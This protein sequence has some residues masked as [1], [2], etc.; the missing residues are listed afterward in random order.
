ME[1]KMENMWA[2]KL[3][4]K[5]FNT[6]LFNQLQLLMNQTSVD[7]TIFFRELSHIP[8]DLEPIKKSFYNDISSNK[9]LKIS[10]EDWLK[11]WKTLIE[12]STSTTQEIS[13]QMLSTNPKY[14][15]REWILVPAYEK[16]KMG[17]YS[18]VEELQDVMTNPYSRQ[19]KQIEEKYYKRKPSQFFEIGGISHIS[20]SS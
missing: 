16:A 15:L 19:S 8:Q 20:C 6:E 5:T 4:L 1:K 9:T 7:Y 11:N 3:G 10:W 2:K 17:D 12:N 18:L 13:K 14:T